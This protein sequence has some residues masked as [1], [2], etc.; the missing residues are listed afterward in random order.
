MKTLRHLFIFAALS[1]L[2]TAGR[3]QVVYTNSNTGTSVS[4]NVAS[5]TAVQTFTGFTSLSSVTWTLTNAGAAHSET[6][7]SYIV[8]WDAT[9]NV[10]VGGLTNFGSNTSLNTTGSGNVTFTSSWTAPDP[11]L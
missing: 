5:Y 11:S 2:A 8:A 9:N 10:M 1:L 6:F 3:A 4:L 7:T